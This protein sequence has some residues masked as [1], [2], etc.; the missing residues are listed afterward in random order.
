MRVR[1]R[2]DGKRAVM[3]MY[4]SSRLFRLPL[5]RHYSALVL[6]RRCF[7]KAAW[8]SERLIRH[9]MIH[10]EQMDR[11]GVTL[12]YLIYLK[13]YLKWLWIYRNH[14]KAYANIP[15]ERE[16]YRLESEGQVLAQTEGK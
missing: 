10:Q 8:A 1:M 5:L 12:F 14:D 13:D 16:A 6:G 4:Y 3:K 15:F 7:V 9:E 2:Q 11:H